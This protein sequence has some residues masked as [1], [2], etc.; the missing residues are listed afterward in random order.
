MKSVAPPREPS[1]RTGRPVPNLR[2]LPA[3]GR[4][5]AGPEPV[6]LRREQTVIPYVSHLTSPGLSRAGDWPSIDGHPPRRTVR[7]GEAGG[8]GL[9]RLGWVGLR[10]APP[11]GSN[12]SDRG[13]LSFASRQLGTG[14]KR[15]PEPLGASPPPGRR[16]RAGTG[17]PFL[18]IVY[19][20]WNPLTGPC[21]DWISRPYKG[22]KT[23]RGVLPSSV[24]WPTGDSLADSRLRRPGT[25]LER[26]ESFQR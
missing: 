12:P 20:P 26:R 8:A 16:G 18:T 23:S 10:G 11:P 1:A 22:E 9:G 5:S 2:R 7:L 21:R 19:P 15:V 25:V 14:D 13:L 3:M 6:R 24:G 17:S 4:Q